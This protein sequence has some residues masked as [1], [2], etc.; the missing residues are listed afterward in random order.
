VVDT[1]DKAQDWRFRADE[2]RRRA[3]DTHERIARDSLLELADAAD[4]HA[5]ILEEAAITFHSLPN[6]AKRLRNRFGRRRRG[7]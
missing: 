6:L 3:D 1:L 2:L 4:H 5:R 7:D